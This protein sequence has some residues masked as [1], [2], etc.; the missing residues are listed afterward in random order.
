MRLKPSNDGYENPGPLASI[1]FV[2]PAG[3]L[4]L[5]PARELD[6]VIPCIRDLDFLELWRPFIQPYHIIIIQ[7]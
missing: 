2:Q 6:V 1:G 5:P 7:V 4:E 3:K